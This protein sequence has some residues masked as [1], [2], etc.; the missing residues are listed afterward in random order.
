MTVLRQQTPQ[1][2]NFNGHKK[3]VIIQGSIINPKMT[4]NKI[5]KKIIILIYDNAPD[6]DYEL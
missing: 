3:Y 1:N 6:Y 2:Q 4:N 5:R